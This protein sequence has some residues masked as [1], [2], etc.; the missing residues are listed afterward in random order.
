MSTFHAG[1]CNSKCFKDDW[2]A[3]KTNNKNGIVQEI[4]ALSIMKYL[5]EKYFGLRK[6]LEERMSRKCLS[7]GDTFYESLTT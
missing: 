5:V 4:S 7:S 3:D 1:Y 6:V 2:Q